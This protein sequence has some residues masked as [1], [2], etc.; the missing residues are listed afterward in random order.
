MLEYIAVDRLNTIWPAVLPWFESIEARSKG[1]ESVALIRSD[2][3]TENAQLWC[4]WR[5]GLKALAVTE[6]KQHPGVKVC[7]VRICT[8]AERHLWLAKGLEG[9]EAWAKSIGC[10]E[11]DADARIGWERDLKG[12]GYRK[13]HFF[14]SKRIA[15]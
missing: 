14:C 4:W 5:H 6:I 7:H 10:D 3:E 1:R 12:L 11:I 2:L 15:P 13:H 8:G 9:I